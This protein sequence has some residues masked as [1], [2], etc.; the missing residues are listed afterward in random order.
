MAGAPAYSMMIDPQPQ[1]GAHLSSG[2][3]LKM[4]TG[5]IGILRSTLL[6][7]FGLYSGL[8]VATYLTAQA[9][10]RAE[11]KDWLW[12]SAQVL[13]AWLMAV[14]R[15]MY[16]HGLTFSDAWKGLS[17]SEKLLFGGVTV[18][19]TRLFARIAS[20]SLARGKDD[21][22]YDA[23]KKEPGFWKSALFQMFLPEAA[24]LSIISLPFTVPFVASRTT[25][26]LGAETLD[27]VRALGVGLFSSGF[28]LEVLADSQVEHHRQE[29]SDLCRH[30]VWSIVRH[31]NYLGDTLVHLSFLVLN[32]TNKFNPL[33]LLGP[34]TNYLF[35]RF[36]GGDK[37]TE[38]SQEERYRENAPEKYEQLCAWRK[39]KNSFWPSLREITNPWTLA[40]L[41][42]GFVGVGLERALRRSLAL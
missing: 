40:V 31:P 38:Q 10:D 24:V 16:E 12:P 14:G 27:A 41:G 3:S 30:G 25:L 34:L 18:W 2:P 35:L 29:R 11:G 5:D 20:R 37:Q 23:P 17:W 1:I 4:T 22:R 9:T 19:G 7:S 8:S 13:N 39:E 26:S 28:A 36:V 32:I 42:C 15:P 6:P 21:S 33:V